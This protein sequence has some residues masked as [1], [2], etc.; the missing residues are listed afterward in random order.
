METKDLAEL[1]DKIT[2][3]RRLPVEVRKRIIIY[4]DEHATDIESWMAYAQ[5]YYQE[6]L[7]WIASS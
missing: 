6:C 3:N 4:A 1:L 7:A 2:N 5:Y